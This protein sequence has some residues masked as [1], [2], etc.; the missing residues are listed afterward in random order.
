MKDRKTMTIWG[1][2]CALA[3][4]VLLLACTGFGALRLLR[5]PEAVTEGKALE[6]GT[7][8]SVDLAFVM[9]VIGVERNASGV[10]TAY[11]AV[12]PVGDTF[13]LV[14][15]PASDAGNMRTRGRDGRLPAGKI[16]DTAL[17]AG[18]HGRRT[19]HGRGHR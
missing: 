5:G 6:D 9:D 10:E 8:V 3:L 1:A 2:I 17:P 13:V 7:Y 4:A 18:R 15:F 14:R 19:E 11:Y 12:S 16:P